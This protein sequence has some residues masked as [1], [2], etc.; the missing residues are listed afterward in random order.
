M[1]KLVKKKPKLGKEKKQALEQSER[2]KVF[3]IPLEDIELFEG[4]P[5]EQD[6]KTFDMLVD[7]IRDDGFNE[8]V[9]VA[10]RK[11]GRYQMIGG[12]HRFKAA[13]YLNYDTI[14][15]IVHED[16]DDMKQELEVVA[17]NMIRG[18]LN[19]DKFTSFIENFQKKFKLDREVMRAAMG[20]TSTDAFNNMIKNVEKNMTPRQKQKL[21]QAKEKIKSVDDLSSI[22]NTIFKENGSEL[23][24]GYCVFS[25][26]GKNHH[27]IQIDKA[28]DKK[29][30][31]I[32]EAC[33]DSGVSIQEFFGSILS[34]V[35][36]SSINSQKKPVTVKRKP[37]G[38][39]IKITKDNEAEAEA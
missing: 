2:V 8:P 6:D 39:K 24:Q 25:F 35:D 22:L 19:K 11:D 5:N 27:Y 33:M 28:S 30:A 34:Q 26:G 12:H 3:E 10:K 29:L 20:F 16:W 17:Q 38:K 7:R 37:N 4:N 21:K 23:E 36:V 14:P 1:S 31:Q 32:T 13:K 18:N 15:A 9:H